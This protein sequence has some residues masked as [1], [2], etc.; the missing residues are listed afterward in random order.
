VRKATV[1]TC[2]CFILVSQFVCL[3]PTLEPRAHTKEG[4]FRYWHEPEEFGDAAIPSAIGGATDA[5]PWRV[6]ASWGW[7]P[8]RNLVGRDRHVRPPTPL[9]SPL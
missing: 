3:C 9:C 2:G 4:D 6:L 8:A 5:P 7:S 1:V